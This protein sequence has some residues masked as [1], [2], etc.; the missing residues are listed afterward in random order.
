MKNKMKKVFALGLA[1]SLTLSLAL[2]VE[3]AFAKA[4]ATK[5]IVAPLTVITT[6]D[7]GLMGGTSVSSWNKSGIFSSDFKAYTVSADV[8][9]PLSMVKNDDGSV[10]IDP[11]VV[12]WFEELG[13]NGFLESDVAIRVGFDYENNCPFFFGLEKGTDAQIDDLSYVK[14]VKVVG[15]MVK[16][17]IVDAPVNPTFKTQEWDEATG[18]NKAW[19]DPIPATG[20]AVPQIRVSKDRAYEGKFA[21]ANASVKVGDKVY[22]TDYSKSGAIGNY[23]GEV[24][25]YNEVGAE[26]F[27]TSAVEVAKKAVKVKKGKSATVKVTTMFEGDKVKVSSSSAK[28]AKA[29]YKNGKLVIKGIKKGKATVSVTANGVTKKIKVTVK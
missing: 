13:V 29:S 5:G 24:E 15:D 16:V 25:G 1:L 3:P 19:T 23:V 27:S 17:E 10:F 22:K 18:S 6:D 4:K 14:D 9:L 12:F 20:D 7:G 8:Y 11:E 28:V 2:G 21:V 26:T